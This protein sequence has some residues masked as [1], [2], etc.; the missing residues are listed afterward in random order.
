MFMNDIKLFVKNEKELEIFIQ[1]VGIYSQ[2]IRMEFQIEKCTLLITKSGK[3]HITEGIEQLN[4]EK[5][6]TFR[7]HEIPQYQEYWKWTSSKKR[8]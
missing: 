4:Q 6:R 8:R 3:R 2:A 1:A 5:I 7:E